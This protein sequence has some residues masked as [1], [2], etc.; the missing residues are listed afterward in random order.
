M[1]CTFLVYLHW[2]IFE[3]CLKKKS[4]H[5]NTRNRW[6]KIYSAC[7]GMENQMYIVTRYMCLIRMALRC[8]CTYVIFH[9]MFSYYAEFVSWRFAFVAGFS[10]AFAWSDPCDFIWLVFWHSILHTFWH[11]NNTLK[12]CRYFVCYCSLLTSFWRPG[13]LSVRL[14][15]FVLLGLFSPV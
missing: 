14:E 2:C 7:L 12:V 6:W 5:E 3:V 11:L 9:L 8:N 15:N 4:L 1:S 10:N 13:A